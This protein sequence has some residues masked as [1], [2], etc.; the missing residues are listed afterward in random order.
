MTTAPEQKSIF[1]QIFGEPLAVPSKVLDEAIQE[2]RERVV[3]LEAQMA[4][5]RDRK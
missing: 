5:S 4:Q 3:K 2:L 1:E